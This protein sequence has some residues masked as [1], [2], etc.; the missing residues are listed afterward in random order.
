[1]DSG[2]G[3]CA[4]LPLPSGRTLES[5]DRSLDSLDISDCRTASALES[6]LFSR[7]RRSRIFWGL[8]MRSL[9]AAGFRGAMVLV[10]FS[11]EMGGG[12]SFRTLPDVGRSD[13]PPDDVVFVD[14]RVGMDDIVPVFRRRGEAMVVEVVWLVIVTSSEIGADR[15]GGLIALGSVRTGEFSRLL[16]EDG[17]MVDVLG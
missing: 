10:G 8:C 17:R 15:L 6:P 1:M 13:R 4:G 3:V 16:G 11:L 14:L 7:V 2:E 12:G 9:P 5:V